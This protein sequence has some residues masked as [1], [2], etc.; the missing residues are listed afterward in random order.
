MRSGNAVCVGQTLHL[1]YAPDLRIVVQI[2]RLRIHSGSLT[3]MWQVSLPMCVQT[4]FF[5]GIGFISRPVGVSIFV[6]TSFIASLL[7]EGFECGGSGLGL[8]RTPVSGFNA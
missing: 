3:S 8:Q 2:L 1:D 7:R 4:A 5:V 6:A